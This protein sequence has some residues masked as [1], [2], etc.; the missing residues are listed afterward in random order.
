MSSLLPLLLPLTALFSLHQQ[1]G[2]QEAAA[3]EKLRCLI[4]DGVN[5]HNWQATTRATR[6]TLLATG[7]FTVDV[8]TSPKKDS[9]ADAWAAWKPEFEAYDVIVSNF[10][11]G[12]SCLWSQDTRDALVAYMQSGGGF[13][14]VHAADNSSADW[15]EYNRMIAV[16]GWGGRKAETHGY[17]LRRT[18]GV[19]EAVPAPDGKSGDHGPRWNFPVHA[20]MPD[21]PILKGL[22][23][24]WKHANDEL[25]NSL[26]GPCKSV[27]VL[28]YAH[29]KVTGTEEPMAML[30][31]CGNGQLFHLPMGHVGGPEDL[32]AVHCVGFQTL[33]ARGAEFVATGKVTLGKPAGFPTAERVS[34][35]APEEVRWR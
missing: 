7:R 5:N 22:P 33:L 18:D 21:H 2:A 19:W 16:G 30:V 31:T 1:A 25:Y 4:L 11:D 6:A 24:V 20:Q 27:S 12:G 29:S 13:V 17:L 23:P 9:G 14:A 15:P 3:P 8:S 10:N 28:A 35:V 26:R 32:D 34:V